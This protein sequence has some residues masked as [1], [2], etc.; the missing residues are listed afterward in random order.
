M[1]ATIDDFI[2]LDIRVDKIIEVKPLQKVA[3]RA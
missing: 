2:K 1:N 3:E